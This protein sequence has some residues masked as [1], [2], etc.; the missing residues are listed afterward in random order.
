MAVG[1]GCAW[2]IRAVGELVVARLEPRP[3]EAKESPLRVLYFAA[4]IWSFCGLFIG[5]W[6]A[7]LAMPLLK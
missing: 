7:R 1:V 4:F 3:A 2:A 5:G 6:A